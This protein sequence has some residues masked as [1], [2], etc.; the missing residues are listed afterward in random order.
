MNLFYCSTR[1][2]FLVSAIILQAQV[3]LQKF[4]FLLIFIIPCS[5][6]NKYA[7]C[8][9]N[10]AYCHKKRQIFNKCFVK[11]G[12]I[13]TIYPMPRLDFSVMLGAGFCQKHKCINLLMKLIWSGNNQSIQRF[14]LTGCRRSKAG[15]GKSLRQ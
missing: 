14:N 13:R 6:P 11:C 10:A 9:L 7:S 5:R 2:S 4:L 3:P 1:A 15:I 8:L 12:T